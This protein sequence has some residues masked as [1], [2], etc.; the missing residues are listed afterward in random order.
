MF[1]GNIV[2]LAV[3]L[4]VLLHYFR[5]IQ[6]NL[7]R[8]RARVALVLVNITNNSENDFVFVKSYGP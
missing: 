1:S 2:L 8:S 7:G 3:L 6:M 4:I 5:T